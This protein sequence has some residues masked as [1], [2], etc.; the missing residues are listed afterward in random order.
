MAAVTMAGTGFFAWPL[1]V[2]LPG[3]IIWPVLAVAV[4]MDLILGDPARLPHPIIW[5]GNAVSFFEQRFRRWIAHPLA[6]G[7][8]FALFLILS[9]FFLSWLAVA[10]AFFIHPVAGMALEAVMLFYCFSA[11]SLARAAMDVARPL[12]AGDLETA[13]KMVG[14]I[15]G[16][17]TAA[18][19]E[20]GVA[21]AACETVAENFVDGFLSPLCFALALGA[22]GAMAYKM[23]NTLD[24]MTGYKN[25][26]YF[27]F[28]RASARIDD[29]ANFIPARI[30]VG[31][32][33]L[34][35]GL[36][37]LSAGRRA[38][39]TARAQ[40]RNHKSPN[41]GYP[42]AAFSGALGVRMGGPNIYHGRVVEKPYIGAG[43]KDPGP[44]D[45]QRACD[46]MLLSS[47]V[48]A[49]LGGLVLFWIRG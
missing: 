21:R 12:K 24:S 2:I 33:S 46:L 44:S 43:F 34:A 28:G 22:P 13:R 35:A 5:M 20:S 39:S 3:H 8:A 6:A 19:D 36:I 15:V 1:E 25:S 14:Y 47:L 31:V 32:I 23:I 10:L 7:T 4:L 11:R 49:L 18:L 38:F 45:I 40:G 17:E 41:A 9:V 37:S 48:S 27:F 16:R 26:R 29:A 30:S 42:E